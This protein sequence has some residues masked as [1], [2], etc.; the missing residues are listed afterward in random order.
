M[1]VKRSKDSTGGVSRNLKKSKS[2]DFPDMWGIKSWTISVWQIKKFDKDLFPWPDFKIL[3]FFC[4]A[5]IIGI[6]V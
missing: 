3:F 4:D 6:N 2:L 5:L 1:H